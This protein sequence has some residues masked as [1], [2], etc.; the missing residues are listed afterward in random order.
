MSRFFADD[1]DFSGRHTGLFIKGKC[2]EDWIIYEASL[3][4]SR[5]GL[6]SKLGG[7]AN[8]DNDYMFALRLSHDAKLA[9]NTKLFFYDI[10]FWYEALF[11]EHS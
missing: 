1:I 3:T 9:E 5:Q 2:I 11:D 4:G 8:T 7:N 10:I 6:G